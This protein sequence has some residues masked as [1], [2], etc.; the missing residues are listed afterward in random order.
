MLRLIMP[1]ILVG[2]LTPGVAFSTDG[3]L[4]SYG[5]HVNQA[6]GTYHC[7]KGVFAGKN[8]ESKADM[9]EA[10]KEMSRKKRKKPKLESRL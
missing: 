5:C 10:L 6:V 3:P 1:V 2:A 8:F 9:L 7:H 4:D